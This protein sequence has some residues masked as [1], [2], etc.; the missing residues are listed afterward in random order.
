MNKLGL[1]VMG[2][3]SLTVEDAAAYLDV[4]HQRPPVGSAAGPCLQ[5][6]R[7]R[8]EPMRIGLITGGTVCDVNPEYAAAA[9]RAA[10]LL[11]EAGHTIVPV[12]PIRSTV[13]E[14]EPLWAYQIAQVPIL[15]PSKLQPITRMLRTKGK[16]VSFER[17]RSIQEDYTARVNGLF[18][19]ADVILSPTVPRPAPK[20]G[21]YP[22]SS[23]AESFTKLAEWGSLTALFNLTNG[24]AASL[25]FGFTS[26]GFPIGVQLGGRL[27]DDHRILALS[28]QL[29]EMAP[30]R[31]HWP[32]IAG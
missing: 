7:K 5:A 3:I 8:P 30:W 15:L 24:P 28:R 29:E 18:D 25:P 6:S 26:G 27:G 10:R 17:A 31:D 12:E 9:T 32:A 13:D 14:F 11:E 20:I 21:E 22:Q 19:D 1:S 2:P 4:L 23:P 16:K